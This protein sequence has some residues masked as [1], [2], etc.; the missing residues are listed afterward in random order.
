M[1]REYGVASDEQGDPGSYAKSTD[2]QASK[3]CKKSLNRQQFAGV[4]LEGPGCT[5]HLGNRA[6]SRHPP[7]SVCRRSRPIP[8]CPGQCGEPVPQL[9]GPLTPLLP[10]VAFFEFLDSRSRIGPRGPAAWRPAPTTAPT[11]S[12]LPGLTK[13]PRP[14]GDSSP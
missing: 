9:I 10:T 8:V 4:E 14:T 1:R 5:V 6:E 12:T 13:A 7:S 2:R 3:T 11:G